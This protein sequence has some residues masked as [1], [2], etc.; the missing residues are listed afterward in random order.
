MFLKFK[1]FAVPKVVE[2]EQ[3]R[4]AFHLSLH[5]RGWSYFTVSSVAEMISEGVQ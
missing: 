1:H 5:Q 2:F 4:S 3:R